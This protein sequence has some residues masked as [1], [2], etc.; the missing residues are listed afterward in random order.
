M[1]A[2]R[3]ALVKR[4]A[5]VAV[6]LVGGMALAFAVFGEGALNSLFLVVVP[7][8]LVAVFVLPIW[9]AA[10][11]GGRRRIGWWAA[12][13]LGG[14]LLLLAVIAPRIALLPVLAAALFLILGW[15]LTATAACVMAVVAVRSV[16][17][18]GLT[19]RRTWARLSW[20]WLLGLAATYGY[21][22]TRLDAE[23]VDIKDRV[24]RYDASGGAAGS[25]GEQSL[26]PLSDTLCGADTVPGFVNP[27]LAVLAVLLAVSV[28]GYTWA[29]RRAR[30]TARPVVTVEDGRRR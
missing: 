4:A 24:C 13:V 12:A 26:L 3:A 1:N 14:G 28:A 9:S 15:P 30:R 6:T 10:R 20:A 11:N 16:W 17:S 5:A 22:L 2:E 8:L 27:L 25:G 18:S 29:R 21:G 19:A 7:G 23:M